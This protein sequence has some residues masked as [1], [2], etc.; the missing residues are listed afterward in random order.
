LVHPTPAGD[1]FS[2]AVYSAGNPYGVDE[3]LLFSFPLR[4][5]GQGHWEIVTGLSLSDYAKGRIKITE[6]ELK[7]ERDAVKP[8]LG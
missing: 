7:E 2:A 4:A 1:W 3:D 5:D 8:M 6:N